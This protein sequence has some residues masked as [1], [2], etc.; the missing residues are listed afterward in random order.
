M[1]DKKLV[2]NNKECLHK[3]KKRLEGLL[4][5]IAKR[6]G[7]VGDFHAK[8]PELGN[9]E[10][11]N[12]AEVNQYQTNIAEERDLEDTLRK[13]NNA[14]VRIENGTYGICVVGGEEM[15]VG[16]LEAVPEAEN[17]VQHEPNK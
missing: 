13:V 9:T 2:Q 7:V 15:P 10:D 8:Y 4:S 17:C 11:E 14:L 1:I 6:D 3:E 12:A 16:R 5:R